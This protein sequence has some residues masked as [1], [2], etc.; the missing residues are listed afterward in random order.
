LQLTELADAAPGGMN[1]RV[2]RVG[3]HGL[4]MTRTDDAKSRNTL[5]SGGNALLSAVG[6]V[7]RRTSH[8]M[9]VHVAGTLYKHW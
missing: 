1:A 8:A 6:V 4:K 7:R 5:A 9:E 2:M 3:F